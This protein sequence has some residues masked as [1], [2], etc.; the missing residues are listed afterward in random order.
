M[1]MKGG[2]KS[3][4]ILDFIFYSEVSKIRLFLMK[5][6]VEN[7][8]FRISVHWYHLDCPIRELQ[9]RVSMRNFQKARST[10]PR[11]ISAIVASDPTHW[12]NWFTEWVVPKVNVGVT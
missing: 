3:E 7:R 8:L 6:M 5:P 11:S 4:S 1:E 12:T 10:P 2:K 9:A